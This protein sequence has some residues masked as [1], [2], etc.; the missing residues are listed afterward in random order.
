MSEE[1]SVCG[2]TMND[3]TKPDRE[4]LQVLEGGGAPDSAEY[5][6]LLL[7]VCPTVGITTEEC[8][9]A[10]AT[11]GAAGLV[12]K[13]RRCFDEGDARFAYA[14]LQSR[15]LD[16]HGKREGARRVL[17]EL[18]EGETVLFFREM[19]EYCLGKLA[20]PP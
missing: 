18:I 12:R 5:R 16:A 7:R 1:H 2:M 6:E 13:V 9:T 19:A 17:Q 8:E 10:L 11:E 20:D 3:T 14:L 15:D 4:L